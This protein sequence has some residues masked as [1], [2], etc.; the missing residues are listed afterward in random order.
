MIF[1]ALSLAPI[2]RTIFADGPMNLSPVS[3][4]ASAKSAFSD[5]K[6]YPG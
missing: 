1:L 4:T 3:S 6:P 2:E 5:K